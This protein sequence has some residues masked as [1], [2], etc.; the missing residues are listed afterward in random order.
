MDLMQYQPGPSGLN[1]VVIYPENVATGTAIYPAP[2]VVTADANSA[3]PA[4]NAYSGS[5]MQ[6]RDSF[7][8][9]QFPALMLAKEDSRVNG[10]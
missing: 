2:G 10:A 5:P 8:L 3:I 4:A 9:E 6:H 7:I 1:P